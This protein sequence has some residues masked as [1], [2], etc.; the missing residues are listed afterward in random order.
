[1]AG[2]KGGEEIIILAINAKKYLGP[3]R[4]KKPKET[5]SYN[6]Q[7][8]HWEYTAEI[9]LRWSGCQLDNGT[10]T[11]VQQS[12]AILRQLLQALLLCD[13]TLASEHTQ[14]ICNFLHTS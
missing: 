9:T 3:I 5:S 8:T 14:Q 11:R 6:M 10:A 12:S 4:L 13:E 1:M 7:V 2:R